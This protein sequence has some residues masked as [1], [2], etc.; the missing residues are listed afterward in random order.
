MRDHCREGHYRYFLG[1]R[2]QDQRMWPPSR[3]G[4]KLWALISAPGHCVIP[5]SP[6]LSARTEKTSVAQTGQVVP[7]LL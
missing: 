6:G 7:F 1:G 2:I 5:V 4:P 3:R